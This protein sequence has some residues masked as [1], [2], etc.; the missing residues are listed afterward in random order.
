MSAKLCARETNHSITGFE[1]DYICADI[2][3]D[4]RQLGSKNRLARARYA[5]D[6]SSN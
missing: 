1:R 6:K 5:E 4:S 3:D 2:L